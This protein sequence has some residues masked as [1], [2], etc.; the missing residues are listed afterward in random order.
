MDTT[1]NSFMSD[2]WHGRCYRLSS[3]FNRAELVG[4]KGLC[5]VEACLA[6]GHKH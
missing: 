4:V 1:V 6:C 3:A 2:S 5:V